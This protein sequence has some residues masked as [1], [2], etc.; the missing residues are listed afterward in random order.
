M[1]TAATDAIHE[2]CQRLLAGQS[3]RLAGQDV[4]FIYAR[5]SSDPLGRGVSVTRQ[6]EDA[7]RDCQRLNL[8]V[9]DIYVDND[10]SASTYATRDREEFNRMVADMRTVEV[11]FLVSWESSRAMRDMRTYLDLAEVSQ[12]VGVRWC[13]NGSV[14]DLS[15]E[16]D[17][18]RAML[19]VTLSHKEVRRLSRRVKDGQAKA[20]RDGRPHGQKVYG[21]YRV[22]D[23]RTKAFVSQEIDDATREA[24]AKDG[25]VTSYSPAGVVREISRRLAGADSVYNVTK[26]LNERGI[27]APNG[28]VWTTWCVRAIA[29]RAT[30]AGW[31]VYRNEVVGKGCWKPIVDEVT[32]RTAK[33]RLQDPARKTTRSNKAKYLLSV[34]A[35]C[36]VCGTQLI[37]HMKKATPK[38]PNKA[39]Y[40]QYRCVNS[41]VHARMDRL[42]AYIESV[43]IARLSEPSTLDWLVR[44]DDTEAQ[45]VA[46]EVT[47]L[48]ARMD[49]WRQLAAAGHIDPDDYTAIMDGL[50]AKASALSAQAV[51]TYVP[52]SLRE[53]ACEQAAQ[54]WDG[55][56]LAGRREIIRS[57]MRIEVGRTQQGRL[58]FDPTRVS[59]T[60]LLDGQQPQR[61][62]AVRPRT[63]GTV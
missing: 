59:I 9:H 26:T 6:I 47:A 24:V 43:I 38:H 49:R 25:T 45:R 17:E 11:Q 33:M 40:L 60:W 13:F 14:I 54:V 58:D 15:N 21:Y 32:W 41:C 34:L 53:L 56:E 27:P 52:L 35:L 10:R 28:G 39:A 30:Y 61:P 12:E 29:M 23:P 22:Y 19:E 36:G 48:R 1:S 18:F 46:E 2:L 8:Y 42:D 50:R 5:C 16:E 37:G 7:W 62:V 31:R 55:M 63:P 51:P 3:P 44:P 20:A 57:I 4:G